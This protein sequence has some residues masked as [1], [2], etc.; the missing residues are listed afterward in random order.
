MNRLRRARADRDGGW[1][2]LEFVGMSFFLFLVLMLV[3]QVAAATYTMAQANGAAHA[4]ARA[5]TLQHGAGGDAAAT[6]AVSPSLRPGLLATG[7]SS[8]DG[9]T[10][11]VTLRVPKVL[12]RMPD[13]TITRSASMPSTEPLGS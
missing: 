3:I 10:W 11:Q 2:S 7:G 6:A 8:G 9:Q 12:P 4:A 5:A 1:L 13:W